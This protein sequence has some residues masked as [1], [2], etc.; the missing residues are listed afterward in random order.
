VAI[1]PLLAS[2]PRCEVCGCISFGCAPHLRLRFSASIS[3][4]ANKER[5]PVERSG[6]PASSLK[7]PPCFPSSPSLP[8]KSSKNNQLYFT[9]S[10][11]SRLEKCSRSDTLQGVENSSATRRGK[12]ILLPRNF[13]RAPA[14]AARLCTYLR[15]LNF[16]AHNAALCV[17]TS[18]HREFHQAIASAVSPAPATHQSNNPPIHPSSPD[19]AASSEH[20]VRKIP[21]NEPKCKSRRFSSG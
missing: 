21:Q 15:V 14:I 10:V 17:R 1:P 5:R 9:K 18:T 6:V 19:P 16:S 3:G 2:K 4:P 11:Q 13:D 20:P 12:V 7:P 8:K